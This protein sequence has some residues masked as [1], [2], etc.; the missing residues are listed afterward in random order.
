MSNLLVLLFFIQG[1]YETMSRIVH[2]FLFLTF[3]SSPD[4]RGIPTATSGELESPSNS[5]VTTEYPR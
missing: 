4:P 1:Y 5:P 2:I 3:P